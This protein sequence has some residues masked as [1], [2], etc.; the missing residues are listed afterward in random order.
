MSNHPKPQ[1]LPF[2]TWTPIC[3]IRRA[4]TINGIAVTSPALAE[5]GIVYFDGGNDNQSGESMA[6]L[7]ARTSQK[8]TLAILISF[9][10][11]VMS[12]LR[13][14]GLKQTLLFVALGLGLP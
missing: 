7:S 4:A 10:L 5:Y 9:I 14:R 11:T 12:S 13:A 2:A 8:T 6:T 1:S 3:Q